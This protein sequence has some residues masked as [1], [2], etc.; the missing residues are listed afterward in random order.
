[1]PQSQTESQTQI[2]AKQLSSPTFGFNEAI[3]VI[4]HLQAR[5]LLCTG[6]GY[7][8]AKHQNQAHNHCE[9][10]KKE[11]MTYNPINKGSNFEKLLCARLERFATNA[12]KEEESKGSN[13]L[14]G[15]EGR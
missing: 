10:C 13:G 15:T 2:G 12:L 8:L 7:R 14:P 11:M 3:A 6:C 5:N 4:G 1:M 9:G